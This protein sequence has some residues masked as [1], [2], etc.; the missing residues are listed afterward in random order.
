MKKLGGILLVTVLCGI[1]ASV[2]LAGTGTA[3]KG[4]PYTETM[5]VAGPGTVTATFD[6]NKNVN[7][8]FDVVT[9]PASAYDCHFTFDGAYGQAPGPQS[10][11]CVLPAAGTY[12]ASFFTSQQPTSVTFSWS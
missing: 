3:K 5:T 8:L 6:G 4:H 9:D 2:A 1:L 11:T 10:F 7:N 12:T